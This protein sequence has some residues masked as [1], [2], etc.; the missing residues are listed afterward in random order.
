MSLL[1]GPPVAWEQ[2]PPE[3]AL[4]LRRLDAF[5]GTDWGSPGGSIR[6]RAALAPT[7]VELSRRVERPTRSPIDVDQ[8][9]AA[10]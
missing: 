1:A 9:L 6:G 7:N 3:L 5:K 10:R 2:E 8:Q 4:R